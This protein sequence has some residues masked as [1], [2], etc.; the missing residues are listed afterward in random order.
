MALGLFTSMF[1]GV[2]RNAQYGVLMGVYL[3]CNAFPHPS[4]SGELSSVTAFAMAS[5]VGVLFLEP[6]FRKVHSSS[7]G[8]T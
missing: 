4:S 6:A 2:P 7:N 8:G 1:P 3:L 5:L